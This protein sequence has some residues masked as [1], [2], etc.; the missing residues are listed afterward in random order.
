MRWL[1][2]WIGSTTQKYYVVN[3][4][5]EEVDEEGGDGTERK[6]SRRMLSGA[7]RSRQYSGNLHEEKKIAIGKMEKATAG[8]STRLAGTPVKRG[9]MSKPVEM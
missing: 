6:V 1:A 3:D 8:S 5:D 9:C 4:D 2:A 7:L